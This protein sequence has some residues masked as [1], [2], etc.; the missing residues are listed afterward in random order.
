MKLSRNIALKSKSLIGLE[1]V[2]PMKHRDM[3]LLHFNNDYGHSFSVMKLDKI[4][5]NKYGVEVN[6]FSGREQD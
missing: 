5:G 1:Q 4:K 6:A 3:I 2:I